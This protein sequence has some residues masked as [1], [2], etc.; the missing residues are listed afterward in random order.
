MPLLKTD[1]SRKF[2]EI[3]EVAPTRAL[4]SFFVKARDNYTCQECGLTE[5]DVDL[6]AHHKGLSEN[7]LLIKDGITLCLKC[8]TEA[9][10]GIANLFARTR[11][12]YIAKAE[13]MK[14]VTEASSTE[15]TIS[16]VNIAKLLNVSVNSLCD[17]VELERKRDLHYKRFLSW[18]F[19]RQKATIIVRAG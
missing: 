6:E 3:P 19:G 18:I 11:K 15:I 14:A 17:F 5:E 2:I 12:P 10:H 16:F 4:W 7:R 9:H 8:H 1:E 13:I